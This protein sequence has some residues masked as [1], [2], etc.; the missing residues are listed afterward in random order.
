ME[1]LQEHEHERSRVEEVGQNRDQP[2]KLHLMKVMITIL[3]VENVEN[4]EVSVYQ[5]VIIGG[6]GSCHDTEL[7]TNQGD[8]HVHLD[9]LAAHS[10]DEG[11]LLTKMF[12]SV[13]RMSLP[14]L[15]RRSSGPRRE[16]R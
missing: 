2:A 1:S 10:D 5:V 6:P 13:L 4:D 3:I 16:S 7:G 11:W 12:L 15:G 8:L 14:W 9:H